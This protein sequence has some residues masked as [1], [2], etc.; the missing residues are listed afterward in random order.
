MPF[1]ASLRL[2]SARNS[3]PALHIP[4]PGDQVSARGFGGLALT[5][6]GALVRGVADGSPAARAGLATG[7]LVT[8]VGAT[9]IAGAAQLEAAVAA[10]AHDETVTVHVVRG[11]DELDIDVTFSPEDVPAGDE[12][13]N[14]TPGPEDAG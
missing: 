14:G 13:D 11:A 9:E 5:P 3:L 2:P 7:D 8:R 1:T 6:D 4:A 12:P 10:L